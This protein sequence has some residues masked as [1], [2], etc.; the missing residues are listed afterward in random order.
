MV[1][2]YG[3]FG[4]TDPAV[5]LY[6][7]VENGCPYQRDPDSQTLYA[8]RADDVKDILTDKNF[9]SER[10]SDR[11]LASLSEE[12]KERRTKLKDFFA[13]WPVF[14]DADYHKHV[15]HI[16]IRLLR[17]VD[18]PELVASC[19][20]L[21]DS[22][23]CEAGEGPFDWM[24]RIARPLAHDAIAA[25]TGAADT[26][27]LIDLGGAVMDELATPRIDME[28]IDAALAAVDALRD[29]LGDALADP[30]SAFVAGLA[31]LWND[32]AYGPKSAT[33][34]LTQ[35]V[36]GAYDPLVTTLCV[37]AE[38]VT[39]EALTEL[40]RRALREEV[41]RLATPFRFASRYARR[42]VTVGPYRLDAGD[43]VNLCLGTA[44]LDAH[45][46]PGPLE[47]RHREENPR[48]LSFGAGEHYC[49]GAPLAQAVVGVLLDTLT[50]L[51]VR[52]SVERVEREPELPM[53][54]YRRLDG[55]LVRFGP[56]S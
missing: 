38:K 29:W 16:A 43:R 31:D 34:L 35:I 56:P 52:F 6:E 45:H 25:V 8:F 32:E 53:L 11:R 42:P 12:E 36:T 9:W 26:A 18:T 40:P 23:I 39:A 33:A 47:I 55:R 13:R 21:I 10:S 4:S 48:S 27:L 1:D 15:R 54:R 7:A 49:P 14:S 44:N 28:R 22:R 37:A 51:G 3:D 20:K 30:P 5:T 41:L 24:D 50:R 46:Y 17:D 19:E 2:L